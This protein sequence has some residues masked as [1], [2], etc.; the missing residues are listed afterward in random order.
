MVLRRRSGGDRVDRSILMNT[1]KLSCQLGMQCSIISREHMI[2]RF[3]SSSR[4]KRSVASRSTQMGSGSLLVT[5]GRDPTREFL[6]YL[7]PA[8]TMCTTALFRDPVS[9]G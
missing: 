3:G 6:T 4:E 9:K 1:N 2:L 7:R 8:A 5:L